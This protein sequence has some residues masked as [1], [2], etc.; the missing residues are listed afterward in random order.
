MRGRL[1]DNCFG[2]AGKPKTTAFGA[3][4]HWD[5]RVTVQ[6]H[7]PVPWPGRCIPRILTDGLDGSWFTGFV[8]WF[9]HSTGIYSAK[10]NFKPDLTGNTR[11]AADAAGG[12]YAPA[13]RRARPQV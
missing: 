10:L 9:A 12:R 3:P 5:Q 11:A 7:M 8:F 4:K 6:A 13:L 1:A 2:A